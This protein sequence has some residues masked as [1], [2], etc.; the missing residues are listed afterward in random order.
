MPEAGKPNMYF[1]PRSSQSTKI[2]FFLPG[3]GEGGGG[4]WLSNKRDELG[5]TQAVFDPQ[6]QTQLKQATN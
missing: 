6:Q 3:R 1:V 2:L 4:K 5:L